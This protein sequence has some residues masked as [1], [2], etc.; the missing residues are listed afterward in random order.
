MS[1]E[2]EEF[3]TPERCLNC[4]GKCKKEMN[5]ILKEGFENGRNKILCG[6]QIKAKRGNK[7]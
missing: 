4:S 5:V 7:T 3:F 2:K 6:K 1:K